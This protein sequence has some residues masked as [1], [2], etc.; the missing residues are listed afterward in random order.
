MIW[1]NPYNPS[2]RHV[3]QGNF[4]TSR[5]RLSNLGM[6]VLV[7]ASFIDFLPDERPNTALTA[8]FETGSGAVLVRFVTK[9][10]ATPSLRFRYAIGTPVESRASRGCGFGRVSAIWCNKRPG[11]VSR[12]RYLDQYPKVAL[13]GA[14]AHGSRS[15]GQSVSMSLDVGQLF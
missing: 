5:L 2:C 15:S 13:R 6:A 1:N 7:G 11:W 12:M 3:L 9:F 8:A 10:M 14:A 4:G